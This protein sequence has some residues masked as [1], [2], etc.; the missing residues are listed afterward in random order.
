MSPLFF[1]LMQ[2]WTNRDRNGEADSYDYDLIMDGDTITL[3][4]SSNAEW[5]EPGA[6]VGTI[7]D[8][9]SGLVIELKGRRTISFDYAQAL[10]LLILLLAEHEDKIEIRET[11]TIKSI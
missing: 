4:Y 10:E 2:V 3:R 7:L 8:D 1:L 11:K 9:G 6:K 5:T